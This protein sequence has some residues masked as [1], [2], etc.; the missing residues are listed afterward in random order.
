MLIPGFLQ[1]GVLHLQLDLVDL[2][3]VEHPHGV[4]L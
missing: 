2:Q 3:F 4:G 1:L